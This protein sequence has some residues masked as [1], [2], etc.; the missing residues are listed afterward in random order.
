VGAT[1]SEFATLYDIVPFG[2]LFIE[3]VNIRSRIDFSMR[4]YHKKAFAYRK[5]FDIVTDIHKAIY[6]GLAKSI[7]AH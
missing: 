2:N 3:S 5:T 4:G 1:F 6:K 7:L